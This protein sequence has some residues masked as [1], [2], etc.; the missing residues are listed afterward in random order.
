[1]FDSE[2]FLSIFSQTICNDILGEREGVVYNVIK[3][4]IKIFKK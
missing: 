1:M 3:I 2:T 4:N